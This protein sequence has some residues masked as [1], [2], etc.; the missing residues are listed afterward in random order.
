MPEIYY[1]ILNKLIHWRVPFIGY[2]IRR[3]DID[4][5]P[6]FIVGSGRS[7]NTLL[8]RILLAHSELYIPPETY[9]LGRAIKTYHR[10]NNM[11]WKHLVS[12]IYSLFEFHPEF[13]TFECSL[14]PLVKEVAFAPVSSR[15]L[16]Y[17]LD[18]FYRYH[19][20]IKG[21]T[22]SR[23][24]DKTPLNVYDMPIIRTVFP[25][26]QFIHIVRDG[27]DVAESY[28]RSGIYQ[29]LES[30]GQRWSS[31]VAAYADFSRKF[32]ESCFEV[33]YAN[34]VLKPE[35]TVQGVCDFLRIEFEPSMLESE[36][37]SKKMGDVSLHDHHKS[38]SGKITASRIGAGREGLTSNQ[39]RTLGR[40]I[41]GQLVHLGFQTCSED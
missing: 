33:R 21:F 2:P 41:D 22:P 20:E 16:A 19:A 38:V 9:V 4:L 36:E 31:S 30:A 28:L 11:L 14:S 26:A 25:G 17:I 40:I 34:L 1:R 35:E 18:S 29:D 24:G 32:P 12:L 5:N 10:Y 15:N 3:N 27:C 7:G 6:F 13:V 23:W 8:R 39:K 37:L